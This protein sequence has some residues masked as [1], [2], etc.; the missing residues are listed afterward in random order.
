MRNLAVILLLLIGTYEA[1][2]EERTPVKFNKCQREFLLG[3][4]NGMVAL[5]QYTHKKPPA[6]HEFNA[7]ANACE[8][9]LDNPIS[10]ISVAP[11]Y[12]RK[13]R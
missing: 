12:T 11:D 2:G 9:L 10:G 3:C 8:L 7:Y 13:K 4:L 6:M 5:H 1:F